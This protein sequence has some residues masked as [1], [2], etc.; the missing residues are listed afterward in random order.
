M[1]QQLLKKLLQKKCSQEEV[2]KIYQWAQENNDRT[3]IDLLVES[4]W[5]ELKPGKRSPEHD[6][7]WQ[8]LERKIAGEIKPKKQHWLQTN[9]AYY[10]KI[11]AALAILGVVTL[12]LFMKN[13][14]ATN[15]EKAARKITW[16]TKETGWGEKLT[17]RLADKS[18]VKLNSGSAISY[19]EQFDDNVRIVKVSGEAFFEVTKDSRPFE[20]ISNGIKTT[21]LGTSFNVKARDENVVVALVEGKVM[22]EDTNTEKSLLLAPGEYG[23]NSDLGLTKSTYPESLIAWR[24][25]QIILQHEPLG[26]VIEKLEQWYGVDIQISKNVDLRETLTGPFSNE[27]LENILTGLCFSLDCDYQ[28]E[29]KEVKIKLKNI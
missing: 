7:T 11:A 28:M 18:L 15:E 12:Y 2:Q 23:I 25:N 21:V 17:I 9:L 10:G 14:P 29:E 22:L 16:I 6:Q 27:N 3:T 26:N 5:N 19:P 4:G 20:V 24:H 13:A 1:N 8:D